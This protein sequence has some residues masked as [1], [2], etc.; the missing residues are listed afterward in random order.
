MFSRTSEFPFGILLVV[1]IGVALGVFLGGLLLVLA[2]LYMKRYI[3]MTKRNGVN[4][5]GSLRIFIMQLQTMV[6]ECGGSFAQ[7]DSSITLSCR[8]KQNVPYSK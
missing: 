7:T 3:V 6:I 4:N 1:A 2:V 8:S 5:H